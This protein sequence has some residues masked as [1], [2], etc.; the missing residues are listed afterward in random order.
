VIDDYYAS[1]TVEKVAGIRADVDSLVADGL[2]M[3]LGFY[4]YGTWFG[5]W[6]PL[7]HA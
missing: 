7:T 1:G 4:G 2:L 3:L 6:D 5:R